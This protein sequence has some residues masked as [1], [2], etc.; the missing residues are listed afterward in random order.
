MKKK[1]AKLS[2]DDQMKKWIPLYGFKKAKAE[3]EKN[4][5]LEVPENANPMEDQ[6]TKIST[7][8]TERVSKNELQRLRNIAKS[9]NVKVP[10]F[11]LAELQNSKDVSVYINLKVI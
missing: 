9:K 3:K 8:K 6:F 4:W 11:G 5:L 1:K 7:A 10:R 2:W